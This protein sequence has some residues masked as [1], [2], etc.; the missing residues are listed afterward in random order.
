[1]AGGMASLLR[2]ALALAAGLVLD[3]LVFSMIAGAVSPLAARLGSLL[4]G[5]A[6]SILVN[7]VGAHGARGDFDR[8]RL[9]PTLVIAAGLDILLFAVLVLR[10]PD[11]Q[12]LAALIMSGLARFVFSLIGYGRFRARAAS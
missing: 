8:R 9:R 5:L 1:M 6:A 2:Y 12:P 11:L 7:D 3:S 10:F 4:A